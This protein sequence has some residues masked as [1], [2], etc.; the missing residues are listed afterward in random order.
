VLDTITKP[1]CHNASI[2]SE[3]LD[4]IPIEPTALILQSLRQIPMIEAQPWRYSTRDQPVNQTIIEVEAALFDR[5]V[6]RW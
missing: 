3:F 6:T 2:L 5:A 1:S 4:D